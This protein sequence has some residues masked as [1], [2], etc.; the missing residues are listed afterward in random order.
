MACNTIPEK[1][2]SE[3]NTTRRNKTKS[4]TKSLIDDIFEKHSG[5]F[6]LQQQNE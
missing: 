3:M 4:K 6:R 5:A 2:L 1:P